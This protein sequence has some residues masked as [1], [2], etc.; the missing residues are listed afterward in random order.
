[1]ESLNNTNIAEMLKNHIENKKANGMKLSLRHISKDVGLS[2]STLSNILNGKE[3][4]FKDSTSLLKFLSYIYPGTS[5][6]D[7]LIKFKDNVHFAETLR[8]ADLGELEIE[9]Y[10]SHEAFDKY[11]CDS[12]YHQLV[13]HLFNTN[14]TTIEW[15]RESYGVSGL[16][17]VNTLLKEKSACV[18]DQKIHI[19][20]FVKIS[21]VSYQKLI[22][23]LMTNQESPYRN[24][25]FEWLTTKV[26]GINLELALPLLTSL[27]D[28]FNKK[29]EQIFSNYPGKTVFHFSLLGN[30]LSCE[31]NTMAHSSIIH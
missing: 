13:L 29:L 12:L 18:I 24:K 22:V 26:Q 1:M 28:D 6:T 3:F 27:V 21:K 5:F 25:Q 7:L 23:L 19:S 16:S 9:D 4:R 8:N 14:G 10:F 15:I 17:V 20:K 11:L 31:S 30:K 2:K